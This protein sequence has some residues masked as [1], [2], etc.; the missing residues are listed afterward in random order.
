M[1]MKRAHRHVLFFVW[2]RDLETVGSHGFDM[3]RPLIDER[4]VVADASRLLR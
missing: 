2:H 1:G 4:H 3:G